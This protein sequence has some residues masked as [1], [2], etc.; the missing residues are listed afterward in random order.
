MVVSVI[1]TEA[2]ADVVV[3]AVVVPEIIDEPECVAVALR[4]YVAV[5]SRVEL[6]DVVDRNVALGVV[7]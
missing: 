6:T 5:R 7:E 1:D 3:V 4:E 2:V